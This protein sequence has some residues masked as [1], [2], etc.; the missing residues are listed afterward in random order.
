MIKKRKLAIFVLGVLF[1]SFIFLNF[2]SAK[3]ICALGI[4]TN[5]ELNL[6]DKGESERTGEDDKKDDPAKDEK[7]EEKKL[8]PEEQEKTDK[9]KKEEADKATK[10]EAHE[11]CRQRATET[12]CQVTGHEDI[13]ECGPI[14]ESLTKDTTTG[15]YFVRNGRRFRNVISGGV[16]F[17]GKSFKSFFSS[18]IS[19]AT[20]GRFTGTPKSVI[21]SGGQ[22]EKGLEGTPLEP[23]KKDE[24]KE[25]TAGGGAEGGSSGGGGAGATGEETPEEVDCKAKPD[26]TCCEQFKELEE[27]K[28]T[29][30]E[31]DGEVT[32]KEEA[33]CKTKP[34]KTC[35]E[36]FKELEE[37]REIIENTEEE[38][39]CKE[40]PGKTCCEEFKEL[41]ECKTTSEDGGRP[42]IDYEEDNGFYDDFFDDDFGAPKQEPNPVAGGIIITLG[43]LSGLA[44]W[45]IRKH[46]TQKAKEAANTVRSYPGY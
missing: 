41:E 6:G 5:P 28:T 26:K 18:V 42:P 43:L 3:E 2:V 44:T 46:L 31:G 22:A 36:Q 15:N 12:C 19:A 24:E 25:E 40:K 10:A 23:N 16:S 4:C 13:P 9:K 45:L 38:T 14:I 27:C 34:N 30:E 35:C 20:G 8:S 11:D 1:L 39:K 33:D 17:I 7:K 21:I 29:T 32:P 37:C